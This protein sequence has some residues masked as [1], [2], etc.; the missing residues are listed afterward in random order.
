[1]TYSVIG[2]LENCFL[3]TDFVSLDDAEAYAAK[4]DAEGA[5]AVDLFE[6]PT[7]LLS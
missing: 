4:L 3:K 6:N 2:W 1:M 5:T 7:D